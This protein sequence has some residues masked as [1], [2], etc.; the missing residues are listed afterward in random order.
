LLVNI[1][2]RI[3]RCQAV[4]VV[5][6]CGMRRVFDSSTAGTRLYSQFILNEQGSAR[7]HFGA[8]PYRPVYLLRRACSGRITYQDNSN[9]VGVN[10]PG[11]R[12]IHIKTASG[13]FKWSAVPFF[14]WL[15]APLRYDKGLGVISS[16]YMSTGSITGCEAARLIDWH[17][18]AS[19]N[20]KPC[21]LQAVDHSNMKVG[22]LFDLMPVHAVDAQSKSVW[23]SR[24][25]LL[26]LSANFQFRSSSSAFA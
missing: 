8:S 26:N 22:S 14:E 20:S 5:N 2:R 11:T 13:T 1:Q 21:L 9:R 3:I 6:T 18:D 12:F 19:S 7:V 24:C 4:P 10:E 17:S 23:I 25:D 15:E 16:G